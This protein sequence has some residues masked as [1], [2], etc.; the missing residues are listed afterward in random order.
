MSNKA[1]LEAQERIAAKEAE[2]AAKKDR[3]LARAQKIADTLTPASASSPIPVQPFQ[4]LT[5]TNVPV[6]G[7]GAAQ[8]EEIQ[9]K[10]KLC[11]CHGDR[12]V[13]SHGL[14]KPS[15]DSLRFS[16]PARLPSDVV[17]VRRERAMEVAWK[18]RPAKTKY[19]LTQAKM[20][21]PDVAQHVANAIVTKGMSYAEGIQAALPETKSED[22]GP[23][24]NAAKQAPLVQ[25]AID[26]SLKKR[27]LDSDSR[28]YFVE[29]LWAWFDSKQPN[30]ER[31]T[32][33]AARIL[34]EHF[35]KNAPPS[36]ELAVLRIEGID[37]G[38]KEMFGPDYDTVKN[39]KPV[40]TDVP[41]EEFEDDDSEIGED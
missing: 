4:P 31:K 38:L 41:L 1:Y 28:A 34:G 37:D 12:I 35:I 15:V 29:R 9:A 23:T 6:N 10:P 3:A 19:E 24:I 27:G 18:V 8:D 32:L 39:L 16:R 40:S 14:C 30:E 26:E 36:S 22:L 17:G 20:A 21:D 2:R 25:A 7:I 11:I 33:Q 13:D 5:E